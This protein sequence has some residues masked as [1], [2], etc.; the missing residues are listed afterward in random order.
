MKHTGTYQRLR[1]RLAASSTLYDYTQARH[2]NF[3]FVRMLAAS[4]VVYLHSFPLSHYPGLLG[5]P[6]GPFWRITHTGTVAVAMFFVTSGYLVTASFVNRGSTLEFLKSRILRIFPALILCLAVMVLLVG[7]LFTSL[8]LDQYFQQPEL[9]RYFKTDI[10][11][12]HMRYYLPGVFDT[13]PI[14]A[15]NGSLW[16][17]PAEVRM[18]LWVGILGAL[19]VLRR[20]WLTNLVIPVLVMVGVFYPDQLPLVSDHKRYFLLAALFTGGGWCYLNRRWIPMN[21]GLLVAFIAL[22]VLT[23]RHPAYHVTLWLAI[24]YATLWL[25][26]VPNLH[27]YNRF[28]DYSYGMYIYAYPCQNAL[29]ALFPGIHPAAMLPTAWLMALGFAML[30]WYLVEKPALSLKRCSLIRALRLWWHR[31][32]SV[33]Q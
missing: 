17:L 13:N 15:V 7:P 22:A 26:Y 20:R 19:G 8:P 6:L 12:V 9:W 5:D 23:W 10:A 1:T 16:T 28:G 18:Y 31:R 33:A 32:P 11:L 2:N 24:A 30:S 29:K 25:A 14:T 3:L 4:M 21:T 27:W